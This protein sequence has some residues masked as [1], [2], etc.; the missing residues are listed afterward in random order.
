MDWALIISM[1]KSAA[2]PDSLLVPS[3]PSVLLVRLAMDRALIIRMPKSAAPPDSLLVPPLLPVPPLA[4]P[5]LDQA[6]IIF[7]QSLLLRPIPHLSRLSRP[8]AYLL[9]RR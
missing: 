9:T 8:L 2:P 4:C 7:S 1:L 3:V 5:A 6:L